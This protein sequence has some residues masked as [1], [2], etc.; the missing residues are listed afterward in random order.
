MERITF[1]K[2][3]QSNYADRRDR[4]W[5]TPEKSQR[6]INL[7]VSPLDSTPVFWVSKRVT[8]AI[9]NYDSQRLI[10]NKAV[11]VCYLNNDY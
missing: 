10:F 4:L 2:C 5:Q 3:R 7:Q 9:V 6:L 11:N 8:V 1:G